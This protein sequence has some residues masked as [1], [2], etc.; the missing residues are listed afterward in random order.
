MFFSIS[1]K[2]KM[3]KINFKY[4]ELLSEAYEKYK[5]V[6]IIEKSI[7]TTSEDELQENIPKVDTT[8]QSSKKIINWSRTVNLEI[9]LC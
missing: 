6:E 4:V 1:D 9:V 8:P 5:N 3:N 7:S 2:M